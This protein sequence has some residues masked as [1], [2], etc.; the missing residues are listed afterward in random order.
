[1]Y[2]HRAALPGRTCSPGQQLRHL[3]PG[4]GMDPLA[5]PGGFTP[6]FQRHI[7]SPAPGTLGSTGPDRLAEVTQAH[8]VPLSWPCLGLRPGPPVQPKPK[9]PAVVWSRGPAGRQCQGLRTTCFRCPSSKVSSCLS[10]PEDC[11]GPR[12]GTREMV[13]WTILQTLPWII[14]Q[15]LVARS[16]PHTRAHVH[17][18]AHTVPTWALALPMHE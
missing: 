18:P 16:P 11:K 2:K 4:T 12:V 6:L 5:V 10:I 8:S 1:M 15:T 3:V 9:I 7:L 13:A 17:S 14:F